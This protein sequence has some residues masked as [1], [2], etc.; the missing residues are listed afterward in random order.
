M[1]LKGSKRDAAYFNK[2]I[3]L[4]EGNVLKE[5]FYLPPAVW[6]KCTL[7]VQRILISIV[8]QIAL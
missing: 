8:Y 4:L 5:R 6:N 7:V 3:V 1:Q 2:D